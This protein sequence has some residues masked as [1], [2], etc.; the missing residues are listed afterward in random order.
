M[1]VNRKPYAEVAGYIPVHDEQ[2]FPSLPQQTSHRITVTQ[3]RKPTPP[4]VRPQTPRP[5][6]FYQFHE[7]P[8]GP[9]GPNPYPPQPHRV[10]PSAN[11][12][13]PYPAN[14]RLL[15]PDALVTN[16]CNLII[17]LIQRIGTSNQVI[18]PLE[19]IRQLI[20]QNIH[21]GF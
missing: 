9:V 4:P 11:I 13:D 21:A 7:L 18:P 5:P 20:T 6:N 14:R 2:V 17:Q 10:I 16:M 15:P 3:R 1:E 12:S 19:E 8:C